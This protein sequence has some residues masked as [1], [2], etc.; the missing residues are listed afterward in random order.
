MKYLPRIALLL[1]SV[2]LGAQEIDEQSTETPH[3]TDPALDPIAAEVYADDLVEP[4]PDITPEM[5]PLPEQELPPEPEHAAPG[6]EQTVPVATDPAAPDDTSSLA[7]ETPVVGPE[8]PDVATDEDQLIYQYTRYL[9]LLKDHVYDEADTVAKRVVELTLKVSGPKSTE[10]S[11]ALINLAIV[12]H[13]TGQYD[14]A[15]QNFASA[16]E[17]IENNEDRL[18]GQLVNPLKG[19][20]AS[21]L[22]GGR[23]D[24]ASE[25][26]SRAMHV[27]HVNEGPHN[28]EQVEILESLAETNLRLGSVEGAREIQ[29]IIYSLNAHAYSDDSIEFV[30]S[31]M[32]RADWQH[33]AGFINDERM[34]LRR[35]IRIIEVQV[36]ND[37]LQ[38]VEPLIRLGRT[39]FYFDTS[40][41][42]MGMQNSLSSG[43]VYFKRAMRIATENPET[44]WPIVA[45]ASLALGDYYMFESNS[46]RAF[47]VY[48]EA[49][50]F[51]SEDEERIGYRREFLEQAVL[52]RERPLPKFVTP[53]SDEPAAG[54]PDAILP[55]SM[56]LAFDISTNGSTTNLKVID[57]Q[58]VIFADMQRTVHREMRSRLYRPRFVE[59][60]PVP[61]AEQLHVHRFF[62][63]KA[64]LEGQQPMPEVDGDEEAE[65]KAEE[66]A[67]EEAEEKT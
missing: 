56:T 52:L 2:N 45:R 60:E 42:Q 61:T 43:E 41:T 34:T 51:L 10:F 20:G 64:D 47:T 27:T 53:P 32:R 7:S 15:Q 4:P 44:D 57:A 63:T 65:E 67:E 18:N 3:G 35:A 9:E 26:F 11:K 6:V 30:P 50:N 33:R 46:Q 28:L 24:L 31:L 36:S 25:T 5:A 8:I 12:Q 21:Q 49:W 23:P 14:A 40:G 54:P 16:I 1:V 38:L 29:E 19:L 17:I 39:Y 13:Y 66:K 48:K 22:D 58:P 37:D 59:A 55:G 62:Y